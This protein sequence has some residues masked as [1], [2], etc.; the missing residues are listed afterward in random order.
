MIQVRDLDLGPIRT[1]VLWTMYRCEKKKH[2]LCINDAALERS[3]LTYSTSKYF[4]YTEV[5]SLGNIQEV[6]EVFYMT[7]SSKIEI[8]MAPSLNP[9]GKDSFS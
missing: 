3:L 2:S 8:K 9:S 5:T 4:N 1:K 6:E 7:V